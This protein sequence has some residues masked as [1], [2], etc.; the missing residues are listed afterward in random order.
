MNVDALWRCSCVVVWR[1][2]SDDEDAGGGFDDVVGDGLEFVDLEHSCDLGEE[3]FEEAEVAASD[4]FDRGDGLRVGEVVGVEGAAQSLP[5]T[6][7]DEE[8]FV[9][10]E[11]AVA[12]GEPEA[13]VELGVV[14]ESLVDAGHADQDDRGVLTVVPVSEDFQGRG[15]EAFGLVDDEQLDPLAH[16]VAAVSPRN[17]A[18][19]AQ[20]LI[21]ADAQPGLQ[22][23]D[24][25]DE[26]R[27][28]G[29]DR[30][31]VEQGPGSVRGG[32][33]LCVGL[34]PRS[35]LGDEGFQGVPVGVSAAGLRLADAG[36]AVADADRAFLADG[37]GEF[38]EAAV[39]FR[40]DEV[41]A[42]GSS[43]S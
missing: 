7:E 33:M 9:A 30:W 12:V 41:A 3:A 35:P 34:A 17:F 5:A 13:A 15:R 10:A 6:F 19:G 37:V 29:E 22:V 20:V 14:P 42:H 31:R 36:I 18:G 27:R 16:V 25:M 11:V 2:L 21:D 38:D 43:S 1:W 28:L 40:D 4:A 26:L 39:F 8:E 23:V 24:L 32:V